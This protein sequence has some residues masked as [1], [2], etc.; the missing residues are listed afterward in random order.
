M[1]S[2]WKFGILTD[3]SGDDDRILCPTLLSLIQI[4]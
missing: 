3:Q 1:I 2:G 4:C